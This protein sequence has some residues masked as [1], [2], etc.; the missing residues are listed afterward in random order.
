MKHCANRATRKK[1]S[2]ILFQ[3]AE[4]TN[5]LG[6]SSMRNEELRSQIGPDHSIG[7]WASPSNYL[8]S[9]VFIINLKLRVKSQIFFLDIPQ[10]LP[11]DTAAISFLKSPSAP[12]LCST[13]QRGKQNRGSTQKNL[14]NG[15]L[16]SFLPKKGKTELLVHC[17]TQNLGQEQGGIFRFRVPDTPCH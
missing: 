1:K 16:A 10:N 6:H 14:T 11:P 15:Y 2:E 17:M 5:I 12:H 3:L 13:F 9:L 8:I 4:V 7:S